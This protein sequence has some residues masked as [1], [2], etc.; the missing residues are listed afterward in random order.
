MT[1]DD[2]LSL[3]ADEYGSGLAQAKR[4]LALRIDAGASDALDANDETPVEA[5]LERS[6]AAAQLVNLH[7]LADFLGHVGHVLAHVDESSDP[8]M[9]VVWTVDA[10]DRAHRYI[11]APS[12][13]E[14][15]A[16][17][18]E[19]ANLSPL[20]P[21]ADWI[22][23]LNV[24]LSMPPQLADDD[25][26]ASP[27]FADLSPE[28]TSL[29]NEQVDRDL[30][31]AMLHDAPTQLEKLYRLL[32][33]YLRRSQRGEP[34]TKGAIAEAQRVAHTLKGSGNIIG[35]PG[36]ARIAHRLEDTLIWLDSD[37]AR[38]PLAE[39]AAS[40]DAMLAT[41]TLQQM[42][43]Y[44]AGEDREPAHAFAVLERMH[45]WAKEIHEGTANDFVPQ[46][47]GI[48][49]IAIEAPMAAATVGSTRTDD[50]GV[51]LR[52]SSDHLG[53]LVQRAGQSLASSQRLAQGLRDIERRLQTAQERQ[54]ALR[55]RL[56]ELQ[57]TVERQVVALQ[58][59][60]EEAGEFDPLELDR[61]DA[62]HLLSRVVAEAVQ[63]QVEITDEVRNDARR[64]INDAREEHRELRNQHRELLDARL[65]SFGTLLPRLRRN[66]AQTSAALSKRVRLDVVGEDTAVD[67]DVLAR[68]T[69]PLLHLLRNAIDHGIESPDERTLVGKE[70]EASVFVRCVREGQRVR[71][72]VMDDGRGLDEVA[73]FE[74]AEALGLIDP[75][76][77]LAVS[78]IH[79][80][81][82]QRG[83]ST[84]ASVSDVSGRG[85]GLDIVN[86][87]VKAMKGTLSIASLPQVGTSF[88]LR[89]PVS[90]GVVQAIL[91]E[92]AGERVAIS[93]DQV[94]TV[95]PPASVTSDAREVVVGIETISIVSLA[96]WLGFS[97]QTE[98][99]AARATIIVAEGSDVKVALAVD[100]VHEVRELILQ[101]V[102]SLLRRI[103]GV[104]TGALTDSG[105]PLFVIDVSELQT[106]ARSGVSLSA[107]MALRKR[108]EVE[109]TRVLVVDD[110]LS[111][112]R[113]VQ[114][115]FQD[116]GYEVHTASDGFEALEVLRNQSIALIATDLEMPN[117]NGLELT[118]RVREVPA[119]SAIPVIM[120]TSR[121]GER[122]RQAALDFGVDEYFVKPF[123]D[124]R[125]LQAATQLLARDRSKAAA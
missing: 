13:R 45:A 24:T 3:L 17:I 65:V 113:A 83:F 81:I 117:L 110:A 95:L 31:E 50:S 21:G 100:R 16:A 115:S 56:D 90:S 79:N 74:K 55:A 68:L 35:L 82:L 108:A 51:A 22:E 103:A 1:L 63:D 58:T 91:V 99:D 111:A 70:M 59:R 33:L 77:E 120:I 19:H 44:L 38:E 11:A 86:D 60:K 20:S 27:S 73:I 37:I 53:R 14:S 57:R 42:V 101:D 66:V 105:L 36:I 72:E 5:F 102:G 39:Q 9:G 69:E 97:D 2:L 62:L 40:R 88:T 6:I 106:R 80:L 32:D 47:L 98:F 84:K 123:A 28:D 122:H 61:Y 112:R 67:A 89:V 124:Q 104:Q 125:L 29:D 71:I 15:I 18:V 94:V 41:E 119:W 85:L 107:A 78:D 25:E 54:N 4:S 87:R 76:V 114:Q 118:K 8:M 121:G 93:S 30:L 49:E 23:A 92:V 64:L 26:A 48:G 46:A 43:S 34:H 109:R 96:R 7:G 116:Q 75:D 52:V 12:D 10:L